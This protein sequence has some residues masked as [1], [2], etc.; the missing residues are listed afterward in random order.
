MSSVSKGCCALL[1]LMYTAIGASHLKDPHASLRDFGVEGDIS[2]I[3]AHC[4]AIIGAS[5][6]PL[7]AM[8]FYAASAPAAVRSSLVMCFALTIPPGILV[9]L[10]Y[11]FNDPAPVFPADM[12]YPVIILQVVLAVLALVTNGGGGAS[13]EI[14]GYQKEFLGKMAKAQGMGS[15]GAALQSI[16]YGAMSNAAIKSAIFDDFRCVHCGSKNPPDWVK[17]GMGKTVSRHNT[18]SI[19]VASFQECQQYLCGQATS[20][21]I[22]E[23]CI[24]FLSQPILVAVGPPGPKK[25]LQPEKPNRADVNK[26][27][28]TCIDWAIKEYGDDG[29]AKGK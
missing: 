18:G 5:A 2:P 8:M 22:S 15:E 6:I 9:Q 24:A 19:W 27:A 25:A 7:A 20:L 3:A 11:P 28:R 14:H 1:G 21:D 13:L 29:K 26:A 4:C 10:W 17:N 23:E 12:P 16:V